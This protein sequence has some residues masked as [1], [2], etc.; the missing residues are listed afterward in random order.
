MRIPCH[1]R[2]KR[3]VRKICDQNLHAAAN[4][5]VKHSEVYS[6]V[7][8][9]VKE[10]TSDKMSDY[11]K[12]LGMLLQYLLNKPHE[13]RGFPIQS[14]LRKRKFSAP[15]FTTVDVHV[16]RQL[17]YKPAKIPIEVASFI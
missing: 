9:I 12:S 7:L 5:T 1:K 4:T 2:T 14:S 11:L 16:C 13:I 17:D 10:N 8:T 15:W 6:A 3:L